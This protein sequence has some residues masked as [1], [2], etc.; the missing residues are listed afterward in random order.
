[1]RKGTHIPKFLHVIV[2]SVLVLTSW[3]VAAAQNHLQNLDQALFAMSLQKWDRALELLNKV[4]A[5]DPKLVGPYYSR[6]I[7][8]SKKGEYDKSIE[9]LKKVVQLNP[10]HLEAYGLLGVVYEIK[11]DYGSALKVYKSALATAKDPAS[12]RALEK[13]VADMEQKVKQGR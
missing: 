11:R 10:D 4:I 1:M 9:D 8:Y 13:W 12:K 6:A 3:S 2:L 7:V 5:T